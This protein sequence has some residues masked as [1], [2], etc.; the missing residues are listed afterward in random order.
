[1]G[2]RS[3]ETDH[4]AAAVTCRVVCAA[5]EMAGPGIAHGGWTAGVFDDVLGRLPRALGERAVTGTLTVVYRKPVPVEHE[6]ELRGR[7][8]GSSGRRRTV[9]GE[10]RLASTGALLASATAVM[11]VVDPTHFQRHEQWLAEQAGSP[12]RSPAPAAG[13]RRTT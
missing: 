1:M 5:A 8:V 2:I 13:M 9:E 4:S 7:L 6:L 3:W 10:L 11:V 12:E